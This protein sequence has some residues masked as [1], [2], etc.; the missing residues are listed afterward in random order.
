MRNRKSLFNSQSKRFAFL[1]SSKV[2]NNF[3]RERERKK[4]RKDKTD[5]DNFLQLQTCPTPFSTLIIIK[6]FQVLLLL[7][8]KKKM[9]ARYAFSVLGKRKVHGDEMVENY[10]ETKRI[11]C[12][13]RIFVTP[14]IN[15]NGLIKNVVEDDDSSGAETDTMISKP[16][17]KI[18]KLIQC[19]EE[20]YYAYQ[21]HAR[22]MMIVQ[23]W[24]SISPISPD[25]FL[26]KL[27]EHRVYDTSMIP[28]I[29]KVSF[30]A[31]DDKKVADYSVELLDAVRNSDLDTLRRK[32]S[33]GISM[34]ACNKFSESIVHLAARRSN[35]KTLEFLLNH[36]GE[37]LLVDDYGR[38]PLHDACWRPD[39]RFDIAS[40]LLDRDITLLRRLDVRGYS[41]LHYV[42][43]R[44]WLHWCAFL[45]YQKDKY[46]PDL[47]SLQ[48]LDVIPDFECNISCTT[49][50]NILSNNLVNKD[51]LTR[52]EIS[53]DE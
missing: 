24:G 17:R 41:P 21:T 26:V 11:A 28:S 6:A 31:P 50:T 46:W 3:K 4:K 39:P 44:H 18:E 51:Q 29:E 32:D 35:F 53:Y 30:R 25:Q 45:F 47:K 15:E 8:D 37:V 48:K 7:K 2:F 36:G 5:L 14:Q 38:N 13:H 20:A 9:S 23:K 12:F 16:R 19:S 10:L 1:K 52:V 33:Q 22:V 43:K 34:S 40:L 27:L 42:C 49:P